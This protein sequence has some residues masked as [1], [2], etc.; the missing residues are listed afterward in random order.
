MV[1]ASDDD[2]GEGAYVADDLE[3]EIF[4]EEVDS[5]IFGYMASEANQTDSEYHEALAT[6][7]TALVAWKQARKNLDNLR[8]ARNFT[9]VGGV[10]RAVYK[11]RKGKGKGKRKPFGKAKGKG[12]GSSD[13][14]HGG[15][16]GSA[17]LPPGAPGYPPQAAPRRYSSFQ[18]KAHP[19]PSFAATSLGS[20]P[21][22]PPDTAAAA[23]SSQLQGS[24]YVA[25]E[26]VGSNPVFRHV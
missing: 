14:Y 7:H 10:E 19:R 22:Q 5:A 16:G 23:V 1:D 15:R 18:P 24:Y 9:P 25:P 8:K 6:T 2:G 17:S 13:R 26:S 21:E 3:T 11:V 4:E 12:K 20:E